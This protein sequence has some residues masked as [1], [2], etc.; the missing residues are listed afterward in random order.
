MPDNSGQWPQGGERGLSW[1]S[2]FPA[3]NIR[4]V[5]AVRACSSLW[6]CAEPRRSHH[7]NRASRSVH[8][9]S[10]WR[11]TGRCCISVRHL[12]P[13][14][15]SSGLQECQP[16]VSHSLP[17]TMECAKCRKVIKKNG[18][19]CGRCGRAWHPSCA[20]FKHGGRGARSHWP[21]GQCHE[22]S[23]APPAAQPQHQPEQVHSDVSVSLRVTLNLGRLFRKAQTNLSAPKVL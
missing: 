2:I 18:L 13:P 23:F 8:T 7:L 1:R 11:T 17:F 16:S 4:A 9:V 10:G 22:C 21:S 19:P 6:K 12:S 15:A 5:P 20:G 14:S 3:S